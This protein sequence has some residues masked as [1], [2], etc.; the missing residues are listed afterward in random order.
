MYE[1]S[2]INHG[3]YCLKLFFLFKVSDISEK[4]AGHLKGMCYLCRII[5]KKE[6]A[7]SVGTF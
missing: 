4:K 2:L 1:E 5:I 6:N 7:S 3:F